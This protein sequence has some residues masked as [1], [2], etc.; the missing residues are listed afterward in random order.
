[1]DA[2]DELMTKT[3]EITLMGLIRGVAHWDLETYMPPKGIMQRSE[4]LA[5]MSKHLHKTFTS[6]EFGKT[7]C[8]AEKASSLNEVQKRNLFLTRIAYD[9]QTKVPGEL[10]AKLAKQRALTTNIW[11]K[12]KAKQDWKM[13]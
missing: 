8:E 6:P 2:Y 5:V 10:V 1:M 9:E 3:K 11:K 12:A 13:F 4:Q 7:L